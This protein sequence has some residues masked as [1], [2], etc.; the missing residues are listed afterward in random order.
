MKTIV[1]VGAYTGIETSRFLEDPDCYVYAFEP[2]KAK[3]AELSKKFNRTPNLILLPFAVDAGNGQE[4]LFYGQD[5]NSTVSRPM[6]K[7]DA[8]V[9]NFDM[10]WTIRLD[11]FCKLYDIQ[12]IDYLRIDAPWNEIMCLESI[13]DC[14]SIVERGRI[15]SYHNDSDI[16]LWLK[17]NG[18]LV[19][20]D[21]ISSKTE[22][23]DICFGRLV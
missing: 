14:V 1:E 11:T 16:S 20:M 9:M 7:R 17:N 15:R 18:F 2:D 13:E 8:S 12:K 3:F 5:G 10:V 21:F 19:E 22:Y 6:N 4:P 23:P